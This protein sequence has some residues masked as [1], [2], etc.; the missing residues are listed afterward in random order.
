MLTWSL[1]NAYQYSQSL[2]KRVETALSLWWR[3]KIC[4]TTRCALLDKSFDEQEP[5][6]KEHITMCFSRESQVELWDSAVG[7]RSWQKWTTKQTKQKLLT[8]SDWRDSLHNVPMCE[9]LQDIK[10]GSYHS[11]AVTVYLAIRNGP[12]PS[13]FYQ[14][15]DPQTC[16]Y[17][18]CWFLSRMKEVSQTGWQC[19]RLTPT[20]SGR[21]KTLANHPKPCS[22]S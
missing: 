7:N 5:E 19:S 18:I 15:Y 14:A 3:L 13:T 11:W 20:E 12:D 1:L 10:P 2:T 22:V 4:M 8:P 6:V 16:T 17:G 9:T 21:N